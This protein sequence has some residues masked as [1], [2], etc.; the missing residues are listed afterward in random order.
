[1]S[2]PS[3]TAA[4]GPAASAESAEGLCAA[5]YAEFGQAV[6]SYVRFHLDSAD[7]AE[8]VTSETFLKAVR[9]TE[10][11][12]PE[13]GSARVWIFRIA[14]NALRDHFRHAR[15]RRHLPIGALR[16]LAS[17]APSPEE[18]LLWEEQVAALLDGIA[19]LGNSDRELLSLRY[20]SGLD[21]SVIG[22]ILGLSEGSVRTRTYRA[23]RRLKHHLEVEE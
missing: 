7:A 14:Q 3:L 12:D 11:F 15:I 18:R 13:R 4:A 1:M 22:E 23:L 20:G 5:W 16:D 19:Q 8:D 10:R 17:D 6:Y 2:R 9:S 21:H